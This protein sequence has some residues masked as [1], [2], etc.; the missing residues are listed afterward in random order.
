LRFCLAKNRRY[1]DIPAIM[2]DELAGNLQELRGRIAG[3]CEYYD[4]DT[5]DVAIVAVTKAHPARTIST[6]VAAGLHDIGESRIQEAET[7]IEQV[8]HIARYHMVGHLQSNKA[9]KAVEL[10][11]VIQSVDSLKIAEEINKYA[12]QAGR[13]IECLI[14]VNCSGEEQKFGVA[15]GDCLDLIR[16]ASAL[17]CIK[18]AGLMTIAPFSDDDEVVRAAFR[19]CREL[20]EQGEDLLGEDFDTL[21]MGM[22]NDFELAIAEGSTMIRI[23]TLLFGARPPRE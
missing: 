21:S 3:A 17:G 4:R 18:V 11:D 20:F 7:K 12:D 6:A 15:P 2:K 19:K 16:K 9:K 23:G 14:E 5:D 10:F 13:T 1:E 22:T 8:G